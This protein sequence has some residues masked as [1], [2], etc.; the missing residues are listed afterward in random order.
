MEQD[1]RSQIK[2]RERT[3]PLSREESELLERAYRELAQSGI[4][5]RVPKAGEPAPD[6]RLPNAVGIPVSL[7]DAR[8]HGPVVVTFYRGIW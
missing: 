1:L 2:E 8:G 7:S 6:F 3:H 5:Q 4:T